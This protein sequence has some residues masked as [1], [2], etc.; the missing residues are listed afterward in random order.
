MVQRIGLRFSSNYECGHDRKLG[1][2]LVDASPCSGV[3][4]KK[5]A[6]VAALGHR[7]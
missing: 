1:T 7:L 4:L 6:S 3:E 2:V 5:F